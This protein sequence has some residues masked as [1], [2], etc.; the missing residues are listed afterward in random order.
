MEKHRR[1]ITRKKIDAAELRT[2]SVNVRVNGGELDLI[3]RRREPL[4]MKRGEYLRCAALSKLPKSV[5]E[6]NGKLYSD[7]GKGLSNLNQLTRMA[8]QLGGIDTRLLLGRLDSLKTEIKQV[9]DML[10]GEDTGNES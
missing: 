3:D 4:H 9:R 8:H 7:L 2:F 6:V 5:P 10:M 1:R